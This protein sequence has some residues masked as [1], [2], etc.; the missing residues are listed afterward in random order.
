MLISK[1]VLN[2]VTCVIVRDSVVLS[3]LLLFA[4]VQGLFVYMCS[5]ARCP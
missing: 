1:I 4:C 5:T 2:T 3:G